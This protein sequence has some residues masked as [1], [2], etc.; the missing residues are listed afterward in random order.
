MFR[1]LSRKK[2]Q[3]SHAECIEILKSE[4]RGILSV[5]G[6]DGYPYGTP[7]NHFYNEEDGKLYFHCGKTGH[8]SDALKRDAKASFCV[9]DSGTP[10]PDHWA[11]NF[12]SIIVFGTVKLI[13]DPKKIV[14]IT[15]KLCHKFTRDEA[16]INHELEHF[17]KATLLLE[18]TPEHLCGKTVNES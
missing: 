5:N 17:A 4:K 12:R 18:L 2:Q 8:R 16:Y 11:L 3:L 9:T 15:T 10:T 6:D 7:M 13:E 14:E 1:E